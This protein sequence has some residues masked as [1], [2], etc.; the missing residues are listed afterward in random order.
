[1]AYCVTMS[2]QPWKN[3]YISLIYIEFRP[4]K[5]FLHAANRKGAYYLEIKSVLPTHSSHQET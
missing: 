5:V 1:M 3:D 4:A 2:P